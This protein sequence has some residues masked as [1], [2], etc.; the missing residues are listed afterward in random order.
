MHNKNFISAVCFSLLSLGALLI[1]LRTS[2]YNLGI[3][4]L[5]TLEPGN[6]LFRSWSKS[7]P[8]VNFDVYVF[9]W[10]N[11]EDFANHSTKPIL[12]EIGPFRFTQTIEKVNATLHHNETMSYYRKRTFVFNREESIHDLDVNLTIPNPISMAIAH[13]ARDWSFFPKKGL[14]L[15]LRH[16][17]QNQIHV[18]KP[19]GQILFTGY[20]DPILNTANSLPL[21]GDIINMD[22]FAFFYKKNAS[23]TFDGIFNIGVGGDHPLGQ[24]Y[25]WNYQTHTEFYHE[26]CSS[27]HG[28]AGDFFLRNRKD[29]VLELFHS[30]VCR[31]LYVDYEGN[32]TVRGIEGLKYVM[33]DHCLDNGTY[34]P[35]NEC[36]CGEFC[37]PYGVIYATACKG[38]SPNYLSLPHFYKADPS[39]ADKVIGMKPDSQKHDFYIIFEPTTGLPLDL[40][41]RLQIN[42]LMQPIS[43]I[44]MYEDIPSILFPVLWFEQ[45]LGM[46]SSS[47]FL[48]KIV[49]NS[50]DICLLVGILLI[51][52]GILLFL[53]LVYR[54]RKTDFCPQDHHKNF[55]KELVPLKGKE[56]C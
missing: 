38:N 44:S 4:T 23:A 21:V 51:I 2:L 33:G 16:L 49:L 27:F 14:S 42:I 43:H 29:D 8:G 28:S 25:N 5:V 12:R 39:F 13:K 47:A 55:P 35:G 54:I 9:N 37:L 3:Q 26:N 11:P 30:D 6:L 48:V 41:P 46:P 18:T 40:T 7:P 10:T 34:I 1:A 15:S 22:K 17:T 24:V 19:A 20:D 50:R 56:S 53:F 31:T 45:T 36:T 32:Q 52:L